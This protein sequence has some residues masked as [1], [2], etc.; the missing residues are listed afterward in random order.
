MTTDV[1]TEPV[2]GVNVDPVTEQETSAPSA[3]AISDTDQ[4]Q[5]EHRDGKIFVDGVRVYSRD[6][7]NRIAANAKRDLETNLLKDLGVNDFDQVKNVITSLQEASPNDNNLSVESLRETVKKREQTV[8][9]LQLELNTLKTQMVMGDHISQLKASMPTAWNS[10][11]QDAVIDLMKSRDMFELSGDQFAIRSGEQLLVDESGERPDYSGAV[12]IMAKTLGL[13]QSKV[14]ISGESADRS[15][16]QP[17]SNRGI[18]ESRLGADPEYRNAYIKVRN[19]QRTLSRSEITDKMIVA[20]MA[21]A[22]Q[23]TNARM[24]NQAGAKKPKSHRRK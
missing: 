6:D 9:E 2:A 20:Q 7:T 12:N 8:E 21:G 14:G 15:V 16:A 5:V 24:L 23:T 22:N 1:I 13:P 19:S 18:D 4:T 17:E 10:Q 3:E 11:Q